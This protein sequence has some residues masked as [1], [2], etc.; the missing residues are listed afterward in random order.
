MIG[1]DTIAELIRERKLFPCFFGSALKVEG[2]E[3]LLNGLSTYTGMPDY[4][5][6]FGARVFKISRDAQGTRL[7]HVKITGGSLKVKQMIQVQARSGNE[8][9]V[10]EEKIDQIRIYSGSKYVMEKEVREGRVC[11]LSGSA[12]TFCGE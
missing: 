8:S 9:D 6:A 12:I 3:A 1:T 7:T 2:V 5:T 4:D 10:A 11:A